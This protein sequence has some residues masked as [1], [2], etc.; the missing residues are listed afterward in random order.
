MCVCVCVCVCVCAH[1][2]TRVHVSVSY[3]QC[4]PDLRI[5]LWVTIRRRGKRKK[6]H[7]TICPIINHYNATCI[8]M[9]VHNCNHKQKLF[10]RQCNK[11]KKLLKN[12]LLLKYFHHY[13]SS[14]QWILRFIAIVPLLSA[15]SA[16]SSY[17]SC[18]T[19]KKKQSM[20]MNSD[21][22]TDQAYGPKLPIRQLG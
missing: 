3:T 16:G 22:L 13:P 12:L 8:L 5:I 7:I 18:A 14:S 21:D 2:R 15:I 1:A 9:Y 17:T 4:V 19:P 6:K 20:A 10:D 11:G